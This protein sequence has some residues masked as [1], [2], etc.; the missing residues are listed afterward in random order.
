MQHRLER[1]VL[2][3]HLV[4]RVGAQRL[5]ALDVRMHRAADDRPGP[6][7][8]HLHGEV[9]ERLRPRALQ[10]LHLRARLDLEHAGRLRLL[11]LRVDLLSSNGIRDRSIRS[12]RT[13]AISSTQRST[14]DSIPSPSRSI[15]RKPASPQDS[16]SHC[17]I[18][19]PSIEAGWIGH[20]VDQRLGRDDHPARVLRH[21]PRQPARL[22]RQPHERIPA[23]RPARCGHRPRCRSE[24]VST[25]RPGAASRSISPGGRPSAFRSRARRAHLEGRE[26]ATSAHRSRP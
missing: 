17:T 23:R 16:L 4:A 19:R 21:V 5:A 9:V 25:G 2:V 1:R 12:P 3:G 6:H 22:A 24:S 14:A 10:H 11:D 18:W 7:Q 20:E 8:R 15:F 13:R 26:A